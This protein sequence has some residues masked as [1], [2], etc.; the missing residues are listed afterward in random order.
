MTAPDAIVDTIDG[1][2]PPVYK[3]RRPGNANRH[4]VTAHLAYFEAAGIE[5]GDELGVHFDVGEDGSAIVVYTTDV[6]GSAMTVVPTFHESGSG[7]VTVPANLAAALDLEGAQVRWEVH[8]FD[9]HTEVRAVTDAHVEDWTNRSPKNVLDIDAIKRV[10]RELD[11]GR[12][13]EHFQVYLTKE[14]VLNLEWR[15]GT[16]EEAEEDLSIG[17]VA[18]KLVQIN[19]EPALVFT[20]DIEGAPQKAIKN[21][22][23]TGD[24][25]RDAMMYAPAD[26]LRTLGLV[27]EELTWLNLGQDLVFTR[28]SI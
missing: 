9:D 2:E 5:E 8:E 25:Q 3:V 22:M 21:V 6:D 20:P 17:K 16:L 23:D 27:D 24:L 11:D 18:V 15:E 13:Q 4:R 28:N 1:D 10:G 26:L 14:Q 7:E 12:Y 19:G